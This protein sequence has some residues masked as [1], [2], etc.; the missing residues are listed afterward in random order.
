MSSSKALAVLEKAR[1]LEE[2]FEQ[3]ARSSALLQEK[4]ELLSSEAHALREQLRSKDEQIKQA[5]R[6]STLGN[7]A[8]AL[9][10]EVRNPLGS[11]K[12]FASLLRS[13]LQ[14]SA[15]SLELLSHIEKSIDNLDHVVSNILFFSRKAPRKKAPVNIMALLLE[16]RVELKEIYPDLEFTFSQESPCFVLGDEHCL[17]Q[18]LR[19]IFLNAEQ[20][21]QGRGE[22]RVE[23]YI[24]NPQN[25]FLRISD[26]GP[27][28]P[29]EL[30][31]SLFEPFTTS[32]SEGTGLGLAIVQQL[33]GQMGAS[34]SA[35]NLPHRGA[36]FTIHFC[37]SE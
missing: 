9:A 28:I 34:I 22:I 2:A 16:L 3:F 26:T 29:Q 35:K 33:L 4:Y 14:G 6:L 17:R 25:T 7:M 18:I 31:E 8:A 30:L 12:L 27:G 32:R 10:H 20:A 36:Q 21:M 5:E 1:P 24:A 13:D 23:I 37:V 11:M 19:N 15:A